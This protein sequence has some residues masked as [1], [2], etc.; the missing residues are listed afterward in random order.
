VDT[1]RAAGGLARI[2][3][4]ISA[5]KAAALSRIAGTLEALLADLRRLAGA[6]AGAA[7]DDRRRHLAR[8]RRVRDQAVLYRWYLE[9]QREAVGLTCHES[10]D[11]MYPLP[12]PL[13]P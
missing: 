5:E 8:H 11:E 10:L 3:D 12:D 7:P 13:A 1:A 2:Q 4:E 9:V 6:A